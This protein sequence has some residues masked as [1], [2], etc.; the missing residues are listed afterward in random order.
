M[1]SFTKR[2]RHMYT[3]EA[4]FRYWFVNVPGP[5]YDIS[6]N[7]LYIL[8]LIFQELAVV[9]KCQIDMYSL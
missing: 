2:L 9:N 4:D 1:A 6:Y 7:M 5:I 3:T 8:L